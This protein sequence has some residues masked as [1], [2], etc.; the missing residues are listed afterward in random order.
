MQNNN[1]SFSTQQKLHD[2]SRP[3]S[4]IF[5]SMPGASG[6]PGALNISGAIAGGK[7]SLPGKTIESK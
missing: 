3:V 5:G 4:N 6:L 7:K 2:A 1:F